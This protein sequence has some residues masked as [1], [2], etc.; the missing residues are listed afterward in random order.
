MELVVA[1]LVA[2]A[3]GPL[4]VRVCEGR[5]APWQ[6]LDAF[7]FVSILGLVGL[8]LL[9]H[10]LH[11]GGAL[12]ALVLLAGFMVPGWLERR[13]EAHSGGAHHLAVLLGVLGLALHS[14]VDGVALA[15]P[16]V[17]GMALGDE[18][19]VAVLIHRLPV[20][21]TVWWLLRN[22]PW[23][24]VIALGL[25]AAGTV[26]GFAGGR[27]LLAGLSPFALANFQALL[28]GSLLHVVVHRSHPVHQ[29]VRAPLAQLLGAG[30]GVIIIA[31]SVGHHGDHAIGKTFLELAV[32]SAPALLFA[33]LG[34][35]L[36]FTFIP[37]ASLAWMGRGSALSQ[38]GRGMLF[39]LPLPVCS[40][41]VL[42]LYHSLVRRGVPG[43]AAF[44]FLVATPELGL[45]AIIL[46][47]PLLGHHFTLARVVA[48]ALIAIFVGI[49]L[50]RVSL[51]SDGP[52]GR[53]A[54]HPD[55]NKWTSVWRTGFVEVLD[56]TG[57]WILFGLAVA[58]LI[59]SE[60]DLSALASLPDAVQLPL[61]AA[62]G[63][64]VY[65]CASGATPLVAVLIAGGVSPGAALVFLLTGP[66]T[67]VTTFGVLSRLHGRAVA[68][69]FAAAVLVSAM[70]MGAALNS[71]DLNWQ[72]PVLSSHHAHAFNA[73]EIG[74]LVLLTGLF[75]ASVWR[76]GLRGF[77][78]QVFASSGH[79][80]D[81]HGHSHDDQ[82]GC[83]FHGHDE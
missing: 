10:A 32:L 41:G 42:P 65:V 72:F 39:G 47:V 34:A 66:A 79:G 57:P 2:L 51:R 22:R 16:H 55:G 12:A 63:L 14:L 64:P 67:N 27:A 61:F 56:E 24:A 6:A 8:L 23:Q 18:L 15:A 35:G 13:F 74:C 71:L 46:S 50:A 59:G 58:A 37:A 31:I 26:A 38:A 4:A 17:G 33:Y 70:A 11:D 53:E 77:A 82:D 45:D 21:L 69:G 52:E 78:A 9:P 68:F 80:D 49:I 60:V 3:L 54:P 73:F 28:A 25:V 83:C 7:V 29:Q 19:A 62:I 44:A 1:S 40:C 81:D 5:P 36:I 43:A 20:G 30:L 76:Q 75:I 48:A